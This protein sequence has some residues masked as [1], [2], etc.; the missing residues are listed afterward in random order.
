MA[1]VAQRKPL[2]Q[3]LGT[4]FPEEVTSK[5]SLDRLLA[6]LR[7]D[8]NTYIISVSSQQPRREAMTEPILLTSERSI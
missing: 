6:S 8:D 7:C 5:P 3:G 4:S 1:G 2:T